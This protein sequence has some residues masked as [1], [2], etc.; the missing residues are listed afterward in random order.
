MLLC[1]QQKD[2]LPGFWYM[3]EVRKPDGAIVKGKIP[4]PFVGKIKSTSLQ[5]DQ[6]SKELQHIQ[7]QATPSSSAPA[8]NSPTT[9]AS[10]DTKAKAVAETKAASEGKAAAVIKAA[11]EGK[12]ATKAKAKAKAVAAPDSDVRGY[13]VLEYAFKKFAVGDQIVVLVSWWGEL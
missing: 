4:D 9:Q 11:T 1:A 5:P 13:A 7:K 6:M 3:A 12:A 10:A 2:E 8:T